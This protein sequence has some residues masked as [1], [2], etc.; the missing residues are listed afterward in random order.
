MPIKDRLLRP[1]RD[2]RIS[3]TDRCN[4]RCSYCMPREIFGAG[5]EFLH[6]SD[7]LTFDEI[8]RLAGI[9]RDAGTQKIRLTGGEPLLL[10]NLD[11]LIR[12]LRERVGMDD[13]TLTTNGSRLAAMAPA[14]RAAGLMRLSVSLDALD[15]ATFQKM[16]DVRFPVQRVLEGIETAVEAGFAPVKINAVIRRGVNEHAIRDLV[17]RFSGPSYVMRFIEYMDVGSTNAWKLSDVVPA[18]EIAAHI[19]ASQ[20]ELTPLSPLYLGEVARRYRTAAGG[21]IGI[22][23]SVTQP[24]CSHCNRARLTADGRIFTCL[25]SSQ[26]TDLKGPLR[27]G[28]TDDDLYK[29]IYDTWTAREDRYSELRSSGATRSRSRIEMSAIGG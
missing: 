14:L 12:L 5:Y 26:G 4:F 29:I 3:V 19:E 9:F 8:A 7:V 18:T 10:G 27:S 23:A 16:N 15:D 28:A 13:L 24:F 11:E 20:G 2:L 22:I 6:K 1:L 25:F 17:H 21:E